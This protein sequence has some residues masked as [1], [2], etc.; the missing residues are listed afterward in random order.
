MSTKDGRSFQALDRSGRERSPM[1]V[2]LEIEV[3]IPIDVLTPEDVRKIHARVDAIE[4]L[5]GAANREPMRVLKGMIEHEGRV[6]YG[7]MGHFVGFR[8]DADHDDR[9]K[10]DPWYPPR[11]GGW[12]SIIEIVTDP[13]V[14]L[15]E[16]GIIMNSVQA[17]LQ[18][19]NDHTKNLTTRWTPDG[20]DELRNPKP[21]KAQ[22][23]EL[24]R[25]WKQG[26]VSM[27]PLEFVEK[28]PIRARNY[29]Y[30]GSIQVNVGVDLR[31][32]DRMYEWYAKFDFSRE[33]RVT[34][35][36]SQAL[37]RKIRADI[38]EA[39]KIG[40]S[41]TNAIYQRLDGHQRLIQGNCLGLRGFLTHLA[42]YL[43]RGKIKPGEQGGSPKN[44]VPILLKSPN[45]IAAH[46][47]MTPAEKSYYD[48]N[49]E[50]IVRDLL[51]LCGRRAAPW[52]ALRNIPVFLS[53]PDGPRVDYFTRLEVDRPLLTGK[54]IKEP[55]AVGEY[56]KGGLTVSEIPYVSPGKGVVGKAGKYS[57]GGV[58]VEFRTLPGYHEGLPRW[59]ALGEIFLQAANECNR[60]DGVH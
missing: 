39:V 57:R 21:Q 20:S 42:L 45:T 3:N 9:I 14:D 32:L 50:H 53:E 27:G 47:G 35:E 33:T 60:R 5:S 29:G 44:L 55:T 1:A 51:I 4:K 43:V 6:N 7:T 41:A 13:A 15:G 18:K 38:L 8:V 58:V 30:D 12:D 17:W 19:I 28:S 16:M 24:Q 11:E 37:Y 23:G 48:S 31:Y 46:Y 49:R 22:E 10:S 26:A 40:Q 25:P 56:R 36:A 52:T 2:G 59:R 54:P 34:D